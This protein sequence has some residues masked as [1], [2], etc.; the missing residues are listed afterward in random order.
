MRNHYR[1]EGSVIYPREPW[2]VVS[3]N[4][5]RDKPHRELMAHWQPI[6]VLSTESSRR[7]FLPPL[8]VACRPWL[9][10]NLWVL[11]KHFP[12]TPLPIIHVVA[13]QRHARSHKA[14]LEWNKTSAWKPSQWLKVGEL[15]G[16]HWKLNC[17]GLQARHLE[18]IFSLS[19]VIG[20]DKS[21][22]W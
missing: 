9:T 13:T 5:M 17:N 20:T 1:N 16:Q 18:G 21:S 3:R 10:Q 11:H 22:L 6:D 4:T 8:P 2:V 12:F 15:Q 14:W 19:R 7:Q